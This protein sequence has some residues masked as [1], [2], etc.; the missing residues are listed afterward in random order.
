MANSFD[1]KTYLKDIPFDII[2]GAFFATG[3]YTFV[4]NADFAPGGVGGLAIIINHLTNIPIGILTIIINIPVIFIT[5]RYLGKRFFLRS[6]K[7]IIITAF[8]MDAIFPRF[9]VYSGLPLMAAIFAGLTTG[10]GLALIYMRDSSTGGSDF[11]VL[12]IKKTRPHLS[13]GQ[14]NIMSDALIILSGGF[15][16]DNI[17]AILYGIITMLISAFMID[18]ILYGI[19][20]G[21][22]VFIITDHG[23]RIA[24]KIEEA[25][26]RGATLIKAIGT[27]SK[28]EKQIIICAC[29]KSQVTKV[30]RSAHLIDEQALVIVTESNEVFGEGFK[31]VDSHI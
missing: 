6:I 24:E 27:Y 26:G 31:S 7:S 16:Y 11:W 14:I 28:N 18:K 8:F 25:T 4:K 22:F 5:Y 1:L 15:V 20:S 21:K 2:G 29:S 10:I 19:S 23:L 17:D 13:I 9:P 3:L 12:A 30:R